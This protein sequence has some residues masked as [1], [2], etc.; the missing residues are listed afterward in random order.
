MNRGRTARNKSD[1][2]MVLNVLV[3]GGVKDGYVSEDISL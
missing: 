1:I 3:G 2:V